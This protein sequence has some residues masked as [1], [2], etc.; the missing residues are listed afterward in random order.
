MSMNINNKRCEKL[1]NIFLFFL[2]EKIQYFKGVILNMSD[3][4]YKEDEE[5]NEI[6]RGTKRFMFIPFSA[7]YDAFDEEEEDI[8][9]EKYED[10]IEFMNQDNLAKTLNIFS[11]SSQFRFSGALKNITY[12]F[13]QNK[14]TIFPSLFQYNVIDILINIGLKSQNERDAYYSLLDLYYIVDYIENGYLYFV[15]NKLFIEV[16]PFLRA[17]PNRKMYAAILIYAALIDR[18]SSFIYKFI[19]VVPLKKTMQIIVRQVE[20]K[21][22]V[23]LICDKHRPNITFILDYMYGKLM[24]SDYDDIHIIDIASNLFINGFSY[25]QNDKSDIPVLCAKGI[26]IMYKFNKFKRSMFPEDIPDF[27]LFAST[28][29]EPDDVCYLIKATFPF[30]EFTPYEFTNDFEALMRLAVNNKMN[31]VAKYAIRAIILCIKNEINESC[32]Q[33]FFDL[34]GIAFLCEFINDTSFGVLQEA[35]RCLSLVIVRRNEPEEFD[36]ILTQDVFNLLSRACEIK[37]N[38]MRCSVLEVFNILIGRC[39]FDE[40]LELY[41]EYA[42]NIGLVDIIHSIIED[43]DEDDSEDEE[44]EMKCMSYAERLLEKLL[45]NQNES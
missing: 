2:D 32:L 43:M 26:Y 34:D 37:T 38:E 8:I 39:M 5:V 28:R 17:V 12:Y 10:G 21:G 23:K 3:D 27:V 15:Q 4:F 19:E 22:F 24:K 33:T 36:T 20:E 16:D 9:M 35:M 18:D 42:S 41:M 45:I 40:D 13:R 31:S 29:K 6:R 14:P 11:G 44:T 7:Y 30:I 1:H 25:F